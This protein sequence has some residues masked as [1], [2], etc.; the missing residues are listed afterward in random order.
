MRKMERFSK[1]KLCDPL[2]PRPSMLRKA[3]KL[4]MT[5]LPLELMN[6]EDEVF[7]LP[8]ILDLCAAAKRVFAYQGFNLLMQKSF[9]IE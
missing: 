6:V 5:F 8:E 9:S 3:R 7:R 2:S 4:K 1:G